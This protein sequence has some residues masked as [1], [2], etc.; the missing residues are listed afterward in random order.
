MDTR[1]DRRSAPVLRMGLRTLPR[2]PS[3]LLI[4]IVNVTPDSFSDGGRYLNRDAAI[5]HALQLVEDGAD[6]LDLGGESTRPGAAPVP[7]DEELRRIVPVLGALRARV[8]V[9]ILIDTAKAIVARAALDHGA[10]VVND[11]SGFRFDPDLLPMV[12]RSACGV[13]LMHMQG[14]P[15]TMQEAPEY[16]D[17]VVEVRTWLEARLA[18]LVRAGVTPDRVI[19]DPGIGFGKRTEHNLALLG[20]LDALRAGGCPLLVGASRKRFLG[21]LLDEP[22]PERRTEGDLAIAAHCRAA[23]VAMLRVHDVRA[24]RRFLR[25]LD[26]LDPVSPAGQ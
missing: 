1:D 9:P 19:V 17:V 14:E 18:D 25:V 10:D 22:N 4:G 23:G 13:V 24:A 8:D 16:R 5:V 6:G 26:A 7:V 12:A 2:G 21:A 15:R 3:P 20:N 11:V